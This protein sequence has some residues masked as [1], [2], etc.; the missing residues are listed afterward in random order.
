MSAEGC[1]VGTSFKGPSSTSQPEG[2]STERMGT[3]VE[4][5][6]ERTSPNGSRTGGLKLKPAQADPVEMSGPAKQIK[7]RT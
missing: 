6:S 3:F 4:A 5:R 7:Q 1:K 2:M